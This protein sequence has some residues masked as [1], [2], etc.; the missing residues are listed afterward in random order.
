MEI[1]YTDRIRITHRLTPTCLYSHLP[2]EILYKNTIL[3]IKGAKQ[4]HHHIRQS[5]EIRSDL[6][7]WKLFAAS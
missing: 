4:P 2:M 3:L 7:W 6:A 5:V 1:M